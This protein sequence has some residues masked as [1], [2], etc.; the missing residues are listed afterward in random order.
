MKSPLYSCFID[1][2]ASVGLSDHKMKRVKKSILLYEK[3]SFYFCFPSFLSNW[4]N[5]MCVPRTHN[6]PHI[7]MYII[8][9]LFLFSCVSLR[10][11]LLLTTKLKLFLSLRINETDAN[12][13]FA[14]ILMNF[15]HFIMD[16]GTLFEIFANS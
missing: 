7:Q 4:Y 2:H 15:I 9:N 10:F 11:C 3:C 12:N 5:L 6:T 16:Y 14:H 8:H 1:L 13:V